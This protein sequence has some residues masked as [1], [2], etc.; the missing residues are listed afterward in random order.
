MLRRW[1][2]T[3]TSDDVRFMIDGYYC[4]IV[5]WNSGDRCCSRNATKLTIS[6]L[7]VN[8]QFSVQRQLQYHN[9]TVVHEQ[10]TAAFRYSE[11]DGSMAWFHPP[12]PR[13]CVGLPNVKV[14]L[15]TPRVPIT[16]WFHN[17]SLA[18]TVG[19]S[20]KGLTLAC[21]QCTC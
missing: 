16:I 17:S 8:P 20:Y 14:H 21:A 6:R 5:S 3:P 10:V 1:V 18:L 7:R 4:C 9:T 13:H 15:I 12:S 11:K 19:P 2:K